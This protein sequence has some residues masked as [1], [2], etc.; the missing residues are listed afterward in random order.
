MLESKSFKV[1]VAHPDDEILFFNSM[2][3]KASEIIICF[4][5]SSTKAI[6]AGREMLKS[7]YP[8]DNETFLDI[9]DG[10]T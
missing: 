3:E 10:W 6:S 4:G 2:V 1:I 9:P 7:S 5:P 8:F